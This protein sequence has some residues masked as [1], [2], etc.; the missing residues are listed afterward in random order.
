MTELHEAVKNG[1]PLELA[2]LAELR[3]KARREGHVFKVGQA[4]RFLAMG[5]T[6]RLV[7]HPKVGPLYVSA[8]CVR[9][10][11]KQT[12]ALH[13]H[14]L[15][16]DTIFVVSG[17]GRSRLGDTWYDVVPGDVTYAPPGVRHSMENP[18]DEVFQQCGGQSPLDMDYLRLV[19][20]WP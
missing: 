10:D 12:F 18:R 14:P 4:I 6:R 20:V 7:L 1:V 8:G 19:G 2:Q 15:S 5:G 9:L 17:R 16:S 3:E 13:Q 11:T